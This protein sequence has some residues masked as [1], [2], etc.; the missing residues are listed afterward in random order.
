[1]SDACA[2]ANTCFELAVVLRVAHPIRG[3]DPELAS[4]FLRRW[5]RAH[6]LVLNVED[7]DEATVENGHRQT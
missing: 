1:M 4:R 3:S 5:G 2:D 6:R 7:K